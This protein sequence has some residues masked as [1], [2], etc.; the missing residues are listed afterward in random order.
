MVVSRPSRLTPEEGAL[1]T[2]GK[3]GLGGIQSGSGRVGEDKY[4]FVGNRTEISRTSSPFRSH[5][6]MKCIKVMQ[7]KS[8]G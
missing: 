7:N 1:G 2:H 5:C 3:G 8:M 6:E 4:L